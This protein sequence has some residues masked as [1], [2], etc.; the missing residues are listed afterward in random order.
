MAQNSSLAGLR[1]A[2][3]NTEHFTTFWPLLT[4]HYNPMHDHSEMPWICQ[5]HLF[6]SFSVLKGIL[7]SRCSV[8]QIISKGYWPKIYCSICEIIV[9]FF[10]SVNKEAGQVSSPSDHNKSINLGGK[11]AHYCSW[12]LFLESRSYKVVTWPFAASLHGL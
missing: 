4:V 9:F 12:S 7:K 6:P 2:P 10:A 1:G 8:T 5:S 3:L 11:T